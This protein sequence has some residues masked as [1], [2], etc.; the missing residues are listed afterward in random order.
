MEI[1]PLFSLTAVTEVIHHN[2][3]AD[4]GRALMCVRR[5]THQR[6]NKHAHTLYVIHFFDMSDNSSSS[7]SENWASEDGREATKKE[8]NNRMCFIRN[9]AAAK[10]KSWF[11]FSENTHTHTHLIFNSFYAAHTKHTGESPTL[12]R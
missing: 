9:I 4:G 10:L 5:A 12:M 3:A 8:R 1:S 6:D 2:G 11:G 7:R